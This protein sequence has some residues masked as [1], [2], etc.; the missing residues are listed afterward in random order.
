MLPVKKTEG[1]FQVQTLLVEGMVNKDRL[2]R[3][4][5]RKEMLLKAGAVF[6]LTCR[7]KLNGSSI[8]DPWSYPWY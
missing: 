8:V 2:Q 4:C 6:V 7:L 1:R 5:V 3:N